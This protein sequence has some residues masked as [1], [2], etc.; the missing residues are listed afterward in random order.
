MM[1]CV[2]FSSAK[3]N[4]Y[5]GFRTDTSKGHVSCSLGESYS[6]SGFS[7]ISGDLHS[8]NVFLP[9]IESQVLCDKVQHQLIIYRPDADTLSPC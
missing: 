4:I 2:D 7:Y 1:P 8:K 3:D 6:V 5:C 9:F